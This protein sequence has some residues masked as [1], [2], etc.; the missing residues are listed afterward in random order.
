[1]SENNIE[2]KN[3]PEVNNIN[4]NEISQIN[5]SDQVEYSEDE[6]KQIERVRKDVLPKA[7]QFSYDYFLQVCEGRCENGDARSEIGISL[8]LYSGSLDKN[9]VDQFA[10]D[11][12][13]EEVATRLSKK[14][15]IKFIHNKDNVIVDISFKTNLDP[16]LQ[17][18]WR[19]FQLYEDKLK[20]MEHNESIGE[21]IKYP[22]LTFTVVPDTC[23][24]ECYLSFLNP[25][26]WTLQP[27]TPDT[28]G[29]SVIRML[30]PT[31]NFNIEGMPD[32]V[33]IKQL[34]AEAART[35]NTILSEN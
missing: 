5:K 24:D 16:E 6:K 35:Y 1:M 33:N 18:F 9:D 31:E 2:L 11:L 3:N 26:F 12:N 34:E 25:T 23:A 20:D 30:V 15:D 17:L 14:G 22:L 27:L 7:E 10:N 13:Y 8:L 19:Q 4:N 29:C 21:S 28:E 32:E